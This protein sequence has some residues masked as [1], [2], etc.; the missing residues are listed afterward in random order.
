[1]ITILA[2]ALFLRLVKIASHC[3]NI[4]YNFSVLPALLF[5]SVVTIYIYIYIYTVLTQIQWVNWM[6]GMPEYVI[7]PN[8]RFSDII[9]P[10]T[11]TVRAHFLLELLISNFKQV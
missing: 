11:D 4:I 7:D 2:C 10:T 1:M 3:I 9:V 6:D 8:M 5:H